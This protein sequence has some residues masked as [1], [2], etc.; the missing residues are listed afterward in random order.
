MITTN[1]AGAGAFVLLA[2]QKLGL[3]LPFMDGRDGYLVS[4]LSGELAEHRVRSRLR[5][6]VL[7]P[8]SSLCKEQQ[9]PEEGAT[10][11]AGS[12]RRLPAGVTF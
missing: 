4:V 6:G 8:L 1:W 9:K 5:L 10:E 12:Q 11:T 3:P 7:S 2:S